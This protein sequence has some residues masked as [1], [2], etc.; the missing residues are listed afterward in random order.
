[1]RFTNNIV[2][3]DETC[4][5]VNERPDVWK[6]TLESKG[7]RLSKTKTKYLEC[8]FSDVTQVVNVEVKIDALV[9]SKKKSFKYSWSIIQENGDIDDDVTDRIGA[10]W[11]KWK[12]TSG[13]LCDKIRM[14][15]QTLKKMRVAAMSV[16]MDV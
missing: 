13:I 5:E 3:I 2:L 6:H 10:G 11:M 1:M 4:D 16:G 14:Y 8:K 9:I 7:F 15:L 12:L